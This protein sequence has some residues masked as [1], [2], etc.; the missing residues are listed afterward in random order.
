MKMLQIVH[1]NKYKVDGKTQ[2]LKIASQV[3]YCCLKAAI[4]QGKV[5]PNGYKKL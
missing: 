1:D 4:L 5:R 2:W 3:V